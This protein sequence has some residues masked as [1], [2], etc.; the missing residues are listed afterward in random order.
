MKKRILLILVAVL[1]LTLG[2]GG[3]VFAAGPAP[4]V[5]LDPRDAEDIFIAGFTL[6]V[7]PVTVEIVKW[8]EGEI[9]T[10]QTFTLTVVAKNHSSQPQE[11]IY[12]LD[13]SPE[14]PTPLLSGT[15]TID[16]DGKG[17]QRPEIGYNWGTKVQIG[18]GD[19]QILY[20]SLTPAPWFPSPGLNGDLQLKLRVIRWLGPR[21]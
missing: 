18:P 20:I 3:Y 12:Y 9:K 13:Y 2:I 19:E 11:V 15:V 17:P 1:I 6:K 4:A 7:K 8:P 14:T 5:P 16:Y 21:G 10:G